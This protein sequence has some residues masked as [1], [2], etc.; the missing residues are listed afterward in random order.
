MLQTI[1]SA[2]RNREVLSF[3][4]SGIHRVVHPAAAGMSSAGNDSLRCYQVQGG[5]V[6]PGHEWDFCTISE[7]SNLRT[8]GQH[9]ASEPPGYKKGDR[10]LHP[11]YAEL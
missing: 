4:Y 7:I 2:I 9:F 10:H 5:H 6:T 8:T 1:I 3:T 11:I